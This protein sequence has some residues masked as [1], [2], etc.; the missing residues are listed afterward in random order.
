[1]PWVMRGKD[2][3]QRN[4]Q[5]CQPCPTMRSHN[6]SISADAL[7]DAWN[8]HRYRMRWGMHGRIDLPNLPTEP[9]DA[10]PQ[11]FDIDVLG[12]AWAMHGKT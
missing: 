11:L 2:L 4:F 7:G 1:M 6:T 5:N 3:G 10:K 9:N 12:A 8:L